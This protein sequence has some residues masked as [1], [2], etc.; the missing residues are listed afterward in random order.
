VLLVHSGSLA[1]AQH[2]ASAAGLAFPGIVAKDWINPLLQIPFAKQPEDSAVPAM[3]ALNLGFRA[4]SFN[5][6]SGKSSLRHILLHGNLLTAFTNVY[7]GQ[8]P[9]SC[10][11]S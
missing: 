10:Q 4:S 8:R 7:A 2:H 11:V 1:K 6:L 9:F 5:E 3:F